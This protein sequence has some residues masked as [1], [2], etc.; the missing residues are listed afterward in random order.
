MS[1]PPTL[2]QQG[3]QMIFVRPHNTVYHSQTTVNNI[4]TKENFINSLNLKTPGERS[5]L[6]Y[7]HGHNEVKKKEI[8]PRRKRPEAAKGKFRET[9]EHTG[10]RLGEGAFGSVWTYRDRISREDRAVKVVQNCNIS[11]TRNLALHEITLCRQVQHCSNIIKLIE[12]FAEGNYIYVV[13]EKVQEDLFDLQ[14]CGRRISD[15]SVV[16][17]T[18]GV[19]NGLA[20]L[21]AQGI[22]HRDIKSENILCERTSEGKPWTAKICDFN[23]STDRQELFGLVGSRDFMAPE[24]VANRFLLPGESKKAYSKN[25]DLWSLGV[26]LY[27]M[28]FAR[29]PVDF[30][31]CDNKL[32]DE[33]L[34]TGAC[35]KCDEMKFTSIL[36]VPVQYP[37]CSE[38]SRNVKAVSLLKKLLIF[39]SEDRLPAADIADHPFVCDI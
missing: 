7:I 33:F 26:L 21:H 36:Y 27:E 1:R 35:E 4:A 14:Q 2:P 38:E 19:S 28:V 17:I 11:R 34:H 31:Y 37:R 29:V 13:F 10:Q 32:C 23:I 18:R 39:E 9:Y 16:S 12:Y 8:R 30:T 5:M 15:P 3:C 25:C 6:G 24:V 22:A 20:A